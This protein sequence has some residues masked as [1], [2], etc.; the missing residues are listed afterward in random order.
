MTFQVH[1]SVG[2]QTFDPNVGLQFTDTRTRIA[3]SHF[4]IMQAI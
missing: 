2:F 4:I 1:K 3:W